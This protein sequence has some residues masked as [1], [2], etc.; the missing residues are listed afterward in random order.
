MPARSTTDDRTAQL[1]LTEAA[2][3]VRAGRLTADDLRSACLRRIAAQDG[4]LRAWATVDAQDRHAVPSGPLT[5]VPVGIKD[6]VA[7]A[8]LPTRA[9]SGNHEAVPE[10][11][12]PAVARLRQAGAQIIGKT[13]CTEFATN[14]PAPTFNP[15]D[16]R[17]TP[18]GSSP[19]SAVAV[20]TAMCFASLD[21]QTAGDIVRP[22]AY[23]GIVGFK[24]TLGRISHDGMI[25]VA[26]SIDT[27]GV[28]ARTVADVA[29]LY[30]VLTEGAAPT[31][32]PGRPPRLGIVRDD[33]FRASD[34]DMTREPD[35][36][37]AVL[38][39]EGAQVREL[40]TP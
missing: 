5:G 15:W 9:G 25:N 26:W 27:P 3:E 8:G 17:R 36:V 10:H 29:T 23:N 12:A 35:R 24:P 28:Q 22:A 11:D 6:T 1:S 40:R 19:G 20:A 16:P 37:A 32:S 21:T 13:A 30:G 18:G 33:L 39:N 4:A 38:A 2:D 31:A 34:T 14:D 7:V